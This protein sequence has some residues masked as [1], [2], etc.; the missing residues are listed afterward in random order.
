M[1]TVDTPSNIFGLPGAALAGVPVRVGTR[2]DIRVRDAKLILHSPQLH[3]RS[4]H[5]R[6]ERE[7]HIVQ[8][9]TA[10]QQRRIGRLE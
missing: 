6:D 7:L 8:I 10:C 4:H 2:R 3:I 5:L 9:L 1:H